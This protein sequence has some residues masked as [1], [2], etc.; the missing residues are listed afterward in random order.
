MSMEN[1]TRLMMMQL[2]DRTRQN[3]PVRRNNTIRRRGGAMASFAMTLLT[4]LV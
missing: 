1:D 2:R 3:A 4:R